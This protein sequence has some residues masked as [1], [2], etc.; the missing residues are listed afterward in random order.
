VVATLSSVAMRERDLDQMTRQD[1]R[2][3]KRFTNFAN[4]LYLQHE[5]V[6]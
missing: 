1:D 2:R 5:M 6:L 3:H 4:L